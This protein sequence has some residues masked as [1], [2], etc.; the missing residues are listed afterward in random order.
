[1]EGIGKQI[2]R[3][4]LEIRARR[5]GHMESLEFMTS[6]DKE[7][8]DRAVKI[9]YQTKAQAVK[10]LGAFDKRDFKGSRLTACMA[11]DRSSV[12]FNANY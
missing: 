1:M 11:A 4:M 6:E 8:S 9:T 7:G 2:S 5:F 3:K 12:Y 10:A